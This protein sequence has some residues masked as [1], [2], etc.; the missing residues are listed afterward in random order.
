VENAGITAFEVRALPADP[1]RYQAYVELINASGTE[2]RIDLTIAG[3]NDKRVSRVVPVAAGGT[4]IEMIDLA[5]FESGPVRASV[6]VP[7]DGFSANDVAYAILPEHRAMRVAL[8]TSGNPFLEK[9]LHAQPR[10]RVTAITPARYVGGRGF[11]AIVFDRFA[12][13][14]RPDV[15][16]L[17][18]RPSRVDWLPVTQRE[19]ANVSA[20][21]WSAAHPLLENISLLDLSI[22]HVAVVDLNSL[23][24]DSASVLAS[25]SGNVPLI[26]AHEQAPRWISFSFSLEE[27]N[28]PL[29][30]GFPIFLDNALV[31]L[32]DGQAVIARE[33]GPIEVPV[34]PARVVA[35]DG[36]EVPSQAIARGSLFE[37]DAPG[38]FVVVPAHQRLWVAANLFDRR[39]SAVNNSSLAQSEPREDPPADVHRFDASETAFA[40]LLA[41]AL[42]SL[43]EWWSWNRRM[44]V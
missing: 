41:A 3:T 44:T 35:A 1:H 42:L 10:V 18:F 30:A 14:L 4:R 29:H 32:L 40:L 15:P 38:L 27:S 26:V 12:P 8:V 9:S 17:L 21:A 28:F 31:W 23:P 7:G 39:I 43:F 33:L 24:K 16:A 25:G 36:K 5:D 6:A 20:T 19:I 2:K 11:D 34:S 37:A 13:K 22:D